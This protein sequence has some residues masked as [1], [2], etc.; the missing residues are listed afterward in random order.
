MEES[1]CL[2][3]NMV[4]LCYLLLGKAN[5]HIN[6]ICFDRNFDHPPSMWSPLSPENGPKSHNFATKILL[7]VEEVLD[8]YLLLSLSLFFTQNSC[9]FWTKNTL[10]DYSGVRFVPPFSKKAKLSKWPKSREA[11]TNINIILSVLTKPLDKHGITLVHII[12]PSLYVR[13][14]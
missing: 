3:T 1:W 12:Y 8:I 9:T 13:A 6:L 7:F 2:G 4:F 14:L 11:R 10:F 5:I